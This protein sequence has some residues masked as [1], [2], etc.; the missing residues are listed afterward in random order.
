MK[1]K[2]DLIRKI[3]SIV[4]GGLLAILLC[5]PN[6]KAQVFDFLVIPSGETMVIDGTVEVTYDMDVH[7]TASIEEGA[8]IGSFIYYLD[9][10]LLGASQ[11]HLRRK[12]QT[13]LIIT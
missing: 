2:N 13:V 4:L 10:Y 12:N 3:F 11:F 6:V 7:G 8:K 5:A 9:R 1:K